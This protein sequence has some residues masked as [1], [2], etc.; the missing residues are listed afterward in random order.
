MELTSWKDYKK[1]LLTE[2][3]REELE[4][5]TD[6]ISAII[7]TRNKKK[8]SQ[9]DLE[10]LSGV[11]QPIIA[12]IEKGDTDPRLSTLIRIARPLELKLTVTNS[13]K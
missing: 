11:R 13:K 4:L 9:R 7:K 1:T 12:R 3:E 6:I 2:E 10:S 8:I 5:K